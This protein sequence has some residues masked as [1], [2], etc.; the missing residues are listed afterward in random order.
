MTDSNPFH[1][2][3]SPKRTKI[4]FPRGFQLRY[5]FLVG[6]SLTVLLVFAGFHG[7]FIATSSLPREAWENFKPLLLDSTWR[8]FLVGFLYIVVVT[9]AATFLSH[10]TVGPTERLEEEI[11]KIADTKDPVQP[12]QIREG[13]E[14]DGLVHAINKL[15]KRLSKI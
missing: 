14:L 7:I 1:K 9:I 4:F 5:A 2:S 13:D 11:K 3:M 6:G 12:I 15:I 8:L 10:R